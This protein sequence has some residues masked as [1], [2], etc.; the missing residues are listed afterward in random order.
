MLSRIPEPPSIGANVRKERKKQHL[1]L[2]EL[3][4]KS[5][6]SKAMLSQIEAE[7]AN[8]TIATAW[9]IAHALG[10]D[11]NAML[12]GQEENVR[13]FEIN[14]KD[15]IKTLDSD[16][17]GVTINVLSPISLAEDLELYILTFQ[18]GAKLSSHA[19][20]TGTE[21][22]LTVLQGRVRVGAGKNSTSLGTGDV[23]IYQCDID[24]LIE[25]IG[26]EEARVHLVVRFGKRSD[27][28]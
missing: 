1:S 3:S 20:Y 14:R 26:E 11:F 10:L 7:K 19:H 4:R 25:N 18:P 23:L 24:H 22:Y 5:G 13:K 12:K 28:E 9:K 17:Q 15:D 2:D 8:P 16:Q 27:E 6:V 21:E